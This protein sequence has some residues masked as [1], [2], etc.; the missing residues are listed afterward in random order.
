MEFVRGLYNLRPRQSGCVLTIGAFDGVHRGH[1]EMLR[2]LREQASRHRLPGVVLS[3]EPTPR[4]FLVRGAPP[5]RLTRFRERFEAFQ[6]YGTDRF[7]CLRFDDRIRQTEPD[8]FVIDILVR[9][10]DVR[11]VVVG[12]DFRFARNLAGNVETLRALGAQFGF[13][14]SEVPPFEVDGERVSSSSIRKMLEAGDVTR[15]ARF[16]G[17]PYGIT[18]KVVHGSKLGRKLGFPTANLRLHRRV[19]PLAGVFAVRVS[20]QGLHAAPGVASLGTRPVV[21]GKE[22]LLE[23]HIF[24]FSGD[25]YGRYLTVEFIARLR[26]E[27]W[28]P[29]MD[30]LVVQMHKDAAQAREILASGAILT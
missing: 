26:A 28:F 1:Q 21:N 15:A 2:V 4:E 12:H 14:V 5:A 10:L 9:A 7:V 25:L 24:D 27:L 16:L 19:T 23:A 13:G 8:A 20:G 29:N 6:R 18:G 22:L 11:H 3:F 30:D 17:R